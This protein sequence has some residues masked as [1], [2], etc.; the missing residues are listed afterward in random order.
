MKTY[1]FTF[2]RLHKA[3]LAVG[4]FSYLGLSSVLVHAEDENK[5]SR[6]ETITVKAQAAENVYFQPKVNLSGFTQQN[7]AEIPASIHTVT[8]ERI[9]DQHAKTVTDVV[10]NDASVGDGYAPIGYYSNFIMRG[11]ALN[12]GSSYLLNGNLLRGE[13]NVALENKEQVEI[14]KGISAIQ[15]GMSTPAGV[16][17]YVSKRPKDIRSMTIDADSHGGNVI[18][19][20]FGGFLGTEQLFGYRMNLAHE[21]IHPHVEHA[22]GKRLFGSLALDWN[23]SDRS[24][25]EFDIESQRQRQRSVP[26]YQLLDG[27]TVP[28]GVEWDRLLG[29]QSWSQ[30]VISQ[31][32]NTGLKYNY[33]INKDWSANLIVSQSRVVVDD[34]SAFA[35]TFDQN[36]NYD[37]YDFRSPDDS[38]LTNQFKTG[39]N[40][41]FSTGS[42][43]HKLSLE[44]SQTYKRHAQ[45]DAINQAVGTGNIYTD[46]VNY[47][48]SGATLGNHY[49]SLNSQQ[50]AFNLLD[51][52]DFNNT[53]SAVVGGKLL[54]LNESAY[55]ASGNNIR[56]TNFN[57]FLPQFAVMYQPWEKTHVYASYAK[58]LSD[59][60][61]A[62]W[63]ANNPF[64]TLV[65][66][67]SAQYE[68]G[69]KQQWQ[70]LLFSAALFDLKQDNQYTNTS[71]DFVKDGEQHNLG[72]ELGLQGRLVQ[73]LDVTS[74]LALTRSRL[75]DIQSSEYQDH[76]TQNVP[77]VRLANNISYQVPQVEGL[78]LLAGIQY[79]SS[80]YAN[81]SATVKV[82]SYTLFNVGSAYNFRA[83]GYENTLRFNLDNVSNKKYWRDVGS[84]FGD[85]YLFLGTPRTAKFSWT[86]NF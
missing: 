43:Q 28:T 38:Y 57:R 73:N 5:V 40:G 79:S 4:S 39:L 47:D 15:S 61:Q 3:L 85:D 29:Y 69:F 35:Y 25:L 27:K 86:V 22:N 60:G 62:P 55:D 31:S 56:D 1:P 64:V 30:P 52:I 11:F 51:Q 41:Q 18:A 67:H 53:W 82:P 36:G 33:Q 46:T 2:S 49:K 78:R 50:T 24:K 34:Y 6:L 42:W 63:F 32:L 59:G 13:Q 14:L 83:Y 58:G 71:N 81:K 17:N 66:K 20:D 37:I 84:F 48:P 75:K 70:D 10:K 26:G 54:H 65:P 8:A 74:T 12:L 68:L 9:A 7:L 16:V 77:R 80:K 72:L 76:Q 45:Y 21:E 23:I 19:A 44:L